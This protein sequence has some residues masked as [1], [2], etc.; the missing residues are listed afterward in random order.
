MGA[1]AFLGKM[2]R[3]LATTLVSR[4]ATED[5]DQARRERYLT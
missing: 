5:A 2:A 4:F 1:I 3:K